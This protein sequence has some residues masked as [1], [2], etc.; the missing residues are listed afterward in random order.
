MYKTNQAVLAK[1]NELL[2]QQLDFLMGQT[3]RYSSMLASNLRGAEVEE[4]GEGEA[5]AAE[6]E[7]PIEELLRRYRGG[8][9]ESAGPSEQHRHHSIIL[10]R[11]RCAHRGCK[12]PL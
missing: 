10:C 4:V 1:K 2:Q 7:L 12:W 6:A 8:A 11:S 9:G 5:L 3:E